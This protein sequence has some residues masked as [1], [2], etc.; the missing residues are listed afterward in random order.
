MRPSIQLNRTSKRKNYALSPMFFHTRAT[1]GIMELFHKLGN[2]QDMLIR[3][4]DAKVIMIQLMFVKLDH[5][6]LNAVMSFKLKYSELL[7]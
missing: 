6:S 7:H 4:Q 2:T 5:V 3:P 1:F